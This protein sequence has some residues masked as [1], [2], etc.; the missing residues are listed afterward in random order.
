VS[1]FAGIVRL[2]PTLQT[3][4][5]DRS[6]IARMAEAIRFRGPDAQQQVVS[7]GAAFAFSLLTT[8]PAPQAA[9]QPVTL[10][11]AT[12]FLGDVRIDRRQELIERLAEQGERCGPQAPD[13]EI[14]LR[15]WKLWRQNGARR[16]FFDE[17]YG[18]YS[19]ALWEAPRHELHCFRDVMGIRPFYYCVASGTFSFSN[20]LEAL[21]YAAG[22]TN[23]LDREYVGDF[24]LLS[25][26]PRPQHTIYRSVRKLPAGYWLT[27]SR[28]AL[29]NTRLREL[30]VEEPLW[31]K[32]PEDYVEI[33]RDLLDKAVADRLPSARTAIFLSGGMD[34]SSLAAT[35]CAL[36]RKT[37]ASRNLIAV[38]ADSRPLF[39]DQ[40]GRWAQKVASHLG[41][42][43]QLSF[44]G[45]CTPFCG[46]ESER[47]LFPEPFANPF[48]A[49][50]LHLYRQSAA[51]SRV[52]MLGY[53]GDDV[54]TGGQ[55]AAYLAYLAKKSKITHA[56]TELGR[57]VLEHKKLPP[58]RAG[59][60]VKFARWLNRG[61]VQAG[62]PPWLAEP[63]ARELRLTDR[64]Q[65]LQRQSPAIHPVHSNAYR[66]LAGT[67]WPH[68]F[69]KE[70]SAYIGLPLEIRSPLF[71]YRLLCFSLRL[72]VLPWCVDKEVMRAAMK[73]RLPES[74]LS[75]SKTVL[76]QDP[77]VLH[78]D[79]GDWP[80]RKLGA[81]VEAIEQ[82]VN[83]HIFLKSGTA[84]RANLWRDVSVVALNLWLQNH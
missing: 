39:D 83:W 6:A 28:H 77:L 69:E 47:P 27:F 76:A 10:D 54:V 31:L 21:K 20:T 56:V 46:F 79:K 19:F 44:H 75:R 37:G 8:G 51:Q 50:Y 45:D 41:I 63:F 82:F 84:E 80:P 43:F 64:W 11:G 60:R 58:P 40:E 78:R 61:D 18:D 25:D 35:I 2:E 67:A 22:F 48:R 24:L 74:I 73:G 26:C 32:A 5:I 1:G 72:P 59:I 57:Y 71:D 52:V 55:T 81:P 66:G 34:S 15:A 17:L 70:D 12:F 49:V 9:A 62:F 68:T 65:E 7:D 14:V 36:R 29:K 42:D 3:A 53:G 4:E 16:V 38:T 30:P 13:E 23:E 33:Y